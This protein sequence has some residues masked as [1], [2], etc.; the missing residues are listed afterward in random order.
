MISIVYILSVAALSAMAF[1]ACDDFLDE[2]PDNRTTLDSEEKLQKF[3]TSAY[4][5][6]DPMTFGEYM[7]DNVDDTG[8]NNPYTDR[9]LD[10]CYTWADVTETDNSDPE[11]YWNDLNMCIET[12]N[13][14]LAAI[15]EQGNPKKYDAIRAEALLCRA[16]A[17]FMLVNYFGMHYDVNDNT[18]LGVAIID[19]PE[20][21][22][23][24]K[25][26]RATVKETYAKIQED[27]E[28]ALPLVSD[29]YYKVPKYHF[30]QAAAY[31][32]ATRFYLFS[33]QW[34]KAIETA[35]VVMGTNP[36]SMLR[37]WEVMGDMV[38]KFE[39][40]FRH[41]ISASI[42]A[43]LML[44]TSYSAAGLN[45]GPYYVGKRYAHAAYIGE[46]ETVNALA[47]L[48]G[49]NYN[50]YFFQIKRYSGTNLN[51]WSK[52]SLP[53]LFEYTDPVANIG[54]Y[55]TV[56]NAFTADEVLLSRAEAY[57]M[58]GTQDPAY[59]DK[60][61][62]DMTIWMQKIS[63]TAASKNLKLT[64]ASI[65]AFMARFKYSY[66]TAKEDSLGLESTIKK[67]LNPKFAIDKEGS[68]QE[69]MLQLVLA[70]RR[71]ETLHEGKRW[72]DIKRY[73]IV[74]PRRQLDASGK[75]S[76]VTDWLTVDDPRRAIQIPQKAIDAGFTPNPRNGS[77]GQSGKVSP[78]GKDNDR[79]VS[80]I[81]ESQMAED[82]L[83][84]E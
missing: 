66:D 18:S 25:Y 63:K 23:N 26:E 24:P 15:K 84:K 57:I 16:Y 74:I 9:F 34:D 45:F 35:N 20:T 59:F 76:V 41:Y 14:A 46:N 43:N 44:L 68:V 72:L 33:C 29:S 60:A 58:K 37:D 40:I 13:T 75:P 67:H 28:E 12:A 3:M 55:H 36:T 56:Y 81:D 19:E 61:A 73:G 1:A 30:T 50:S 21:E 79:Y 77:N 78:N 83:V 54:Y 42:P 4:P 53:Y 82:C 22:L 27:I 69:S 48:W 10:E 65:Q 62:E 5:T 49:G 31:G 8:E 70:M 52:W 38:S 32:F 6:H 17:H 71:F 64:P 7:S 47:A 51:C 2:L 80:P 39:A 11:S